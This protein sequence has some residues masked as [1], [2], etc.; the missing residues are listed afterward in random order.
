MNVKVEKRKAGDENTRKLKHAW[1]LRS[2]AGPE[3]SG[4]GTIESARATVLS[5]NIFIKGIAVESSAFDPRIRLR[6]DCDLE[7]S[8]SLG[9]CLGYPLARI[10]QQHSSRGR[11]LSAGSI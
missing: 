11:S 9:G 3:L 5:S 2:T 7:H 1:Y 8:P 10:I 6:T 4:S